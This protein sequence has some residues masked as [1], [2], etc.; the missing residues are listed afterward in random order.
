MGGCGAAGRPGQSQVPIL[1]RWTLLRWRPDVLREGEASLG[2]GWAG[3]AQQQQQSPAVVV[4]V[5]GYRPH[6]QAAY[7]QAG[8]L[9]Q[10][11][12]AEGYRAEG[13]GAPQMLYGMQPAQL[14]AHMPPGYAHTHAHQAWLAQGGYAPQQPYAHAPSPHGPH[15]APAAT[16]VTDVDMRSS[17]ERAMVRVED[18]LSVSKATQTACLRG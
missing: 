17:T 10:G 1:Q 15:G 18:Q 6:P 3:V 5:P 12:G 2:G 11:Y 7:A 13:Y 16:L 8:Q 9:S 14:A 4:P